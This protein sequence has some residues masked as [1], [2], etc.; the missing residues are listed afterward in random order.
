MS[1]RS[2]KS[3]LTA[4]TDSSDDRVLVGAGGAGGNIVE[5]PAAAREAESSVAEAAASSYPAGGAARVEPSKKD[6]AKVFK[7][8][9]IPY[10]PEVE[11]TCTFNR[12]ELQEAIRFS[13]SVRDD[14]HHT[15]F[16]PYE[17]PTEVLGH[18]VKFSEL[19]TQHPCLAT[20]RGERRFDFELDT[21]G[22]ALEITSSQHLVSMGHPPK[23]ISIPKGLS[24]RRQDAIVKVASEDERLMRRIYS[25]L[26]EDILPEF[27]DAFRKVV[28]V[29][30]NC[31]V[32]CSMFVI[33]PGAKKQHLHMD[34]MGIKG[35]YWSAVIPVTDHHDQG[36][37]VFC[38]QDTEDKHCYT[39]LGS[40]AWSKFTGHLG[41]A[42]NSA[43]NRVALSLSVC[44]VKEVNRKYSSPFPYD[45]KRGEVIYVSSDDE[46]GPAKGGKGQK[47]PSRRS[48]R[49]AP[50]KEED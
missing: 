45:F 42:N 8:A 21:L 46:P 30:T 33:Q 40:V 48:A 44:N 7:T 20:D 17:I 19:L 28:D 43:K 34:Y 3:K 35:F 22:L 36:S 47:Q 25:L 18:F 15:A 38:N 23:Q 12:N 11:S 27:M 49:L 31:K 24:Q 14:S 39:Y 13:A 1:S 37:T 32:Y 4:Y 2:E 41:G 5:S 10:E 16:I 50:V 26:C 6:K 9:A 29:P